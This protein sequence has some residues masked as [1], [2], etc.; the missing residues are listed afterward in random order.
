M[1]LCLSPQR[2]RLCSGSYDATIKVRD[3]ETWQCLHTLQGH[4]NSVTSLVLDESANSA[5]C[6]VTPT[7]ITSSIMF[8][9]FEIK[10]V[11]DI[12]QQEFMIP[13]YCYGR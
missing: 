4:T 10:S 9:L 7:P 2:H 11:V 8:G 12:A 3:T 6:F 13:W 1:C 5:P